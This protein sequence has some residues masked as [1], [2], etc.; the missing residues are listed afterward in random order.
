MPAGTTDDRN[1][2]LNRAIGTVLEQLTEKPPHFCEGFSSLSPVWW[3]LRDSNPLPPAC[4]AGALPAELKPQ[5]GTII[6]RLIIRKVVQVNHPI[7]KILKIAPNNNPLEPTIHPT[8]NNKK[9]VKC[10][11]SLQFRSDQRSP[12]RRKG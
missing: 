7:S 4:K 5:T 12:S 11:R 3:S 1:S 10:A 8:A 2:E 6:V 9:V